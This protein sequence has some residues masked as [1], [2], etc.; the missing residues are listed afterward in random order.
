MRYGFLGHARDVPEQHA[1]GSLVFFMLISAIG[2]VLAFPAL[3]ACPGTEV[4]VVGFVSRQVFSDC[5]PRGVSRS[6]PYVIVIPDTKLELLVV[7]VGFR[8]AW[9][10]PPAAAFQKDRGDIPRPLPAAAAFQKIDRTI[11]PL[12]QGYSRGYRPLY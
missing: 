9:F 3:L 4:P 7:P 6:S 1:E 2:N 8:G 5:L 11:S 12:Y 10:L